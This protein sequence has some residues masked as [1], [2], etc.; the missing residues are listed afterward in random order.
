ML[1]EL[2]DARKKPLCAG[3]DESGGETGAKAVV[4]STI[5]AAKK[6]DGFFEGVVGAL[7]E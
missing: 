4:F 6:S 1:G 7:P 2:G 5:P 3:D